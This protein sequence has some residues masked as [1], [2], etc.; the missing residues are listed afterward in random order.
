MTVSW[1]NEFVRIPAKK[2][3]FILFFRFCFVST[4][5]WLATRKHLN[6]KWFVLRAQ[7]ELLRF[8]NTHICRLMLRIIKLMTEFASAPRLR[9]CWR[10]RSDDCP[11]V[12]QRIFSRKY[13]PSGE[14]A[15]AFHHDMRTGVHH[16]NG[17][18]PARRR[19]ADSPFC[20]RQHDSTVFVRETRRNGATE[21][22]F[23]AI[24]IFNIFHFVCYKRH[25][26]VKINQF[27]VIYSGCLCVWPLLLSPCAVWYAFG[28][29][30]VLI[31]SKWNERMNSYC[32]TGMRDVDSRYS[33]TICE[34]VFAAKCHLHRHEGGRVW[35]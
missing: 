10:M 20:L 2:K 22:Q 17:I 18:S 4:L 30:F 15:E 34:R 6:G 1:I 9:R 23:I 5:D 28:M 14:W 3:N 12:R 24:Q 21:A 11:Q 19:N 29:T 31:E 26:R 27:V 33:I 35:P 7:N 13:C 8:M 16:A 25:A 32:G